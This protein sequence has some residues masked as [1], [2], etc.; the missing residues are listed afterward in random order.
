MVL[1]PGNR[2]AFF[3][4]YL[5][6]WIDLWVWCILDFECFRRMAVKLHLWGWIWIT[7]SLCGIGVEGLALPL[8]RA[9]QIRFLKP[10]AGHKLGNPFDAEHLL[11]CLNR[12]TRSDHSIDRLD[13][14]LLELCNHA[15]CNHLQQRGSETFQ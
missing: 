1:L 5:D 13:H 10:G 3:G 7:P 15:C 4:L 9:T 14:L 8:L 2:I 12:I 11:E 6:R